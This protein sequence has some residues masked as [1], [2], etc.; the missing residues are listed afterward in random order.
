MKIHAIHKQKYG[1]E[2]GNKIC[3]EH[4]FSGNQ[5]KLEYSIETLSRR[6]LM[7]S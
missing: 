1:K 6:P 7:L 3:L 2:G 4:M 5:R